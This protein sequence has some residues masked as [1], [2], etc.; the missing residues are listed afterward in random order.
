MGR[1]TKSVTT[2][3]LAGSNRAGDQHLILIKGLLLGKS[4]IGGKTS[5]D[6]DKVKR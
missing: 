2:A 3:R 1:P 4:G 6:D 5:A